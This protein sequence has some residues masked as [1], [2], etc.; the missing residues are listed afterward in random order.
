MRGRGEIPLRGVGLGLIAREFNLFF[1][2]R[3]AKY[4][5]FR[6]CAGEAVEAGRISFGGR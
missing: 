2:D 4:V 5:S 6:G 1:F 3:F